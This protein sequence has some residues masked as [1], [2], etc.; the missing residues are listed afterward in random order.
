M[1]FKL[2]SLFLFT[3]QECKEAFV[4]TMEEN[5]P[6]ILLTGILEITKLAFD[7]IKLRP[8]KGVDILHRN[9]LTLHG[10]LPLRK[11]NILLSGEISFL[12]YSF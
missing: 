4:H 6:I 1:G 9:V 11:E 3:C 2:L 8:A 12:L 7:Q 5:K 10:G